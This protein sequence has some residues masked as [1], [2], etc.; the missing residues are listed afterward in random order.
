VDLLPMDVLRMAGLLRTAHSSS[1]SSN[2]CNVV[3]LDPLMGLHHAI[4]GIV[5]KVP[6]R[7]SVE[8][9]FRDGNSTLICTTSKRGAILLSNSSNHHRSRCLLLACKDLRCLLL[10]VDHLIPDPEIQ[11]AL[12]LISCP[13]LTHVLVCSLLV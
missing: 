9:L 1:S 7:P 2:R 4:I 10:L 8:A 5:M 11:E 3:D 13:R 12:L 6:H